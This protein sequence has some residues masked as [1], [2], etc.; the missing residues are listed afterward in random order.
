[1]KDRK[2]G[3]NRASDPERMSRKDYEAALQKLQVQLCYLQDW[4]KETGARV[5]IVFEGR[6]AAGKGGTIKALTE[7]VS[8]RVFRVVAL[9]APSDREKSQM[10]MQRYFQQFPAAG[11][12]VIFDR[13]WYNRA[14]VEYVMGFC[15]KEQ[16]RRFLKLCPAVEGYMVENGIILIKIWLEVGKEE[17][18]KRFL[19]RI[20]DPLRQ[21]KLSPMD[22]ESYNRW[23]EFSVARNKMLAATDTDHAPWHIVR[24]DDK[25]RARLNCISHILATIPYGKV[26]RKKVELPKRSSKSKGEGDALKGRRFVAERF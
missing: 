7:R 25:R 23:D 2:S 16:H 3:K 10:F 18:E 15:T 1:M 22:V 20:N 14:G 12:I 26:K 5:V 21:W 11:E 13:S 24:S 17:Q 6:D 8:P 9:P 4:V 19:A